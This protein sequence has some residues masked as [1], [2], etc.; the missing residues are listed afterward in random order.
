[1]IR[2]LSRR[3][4]VLGTVETAA[5]PALMAAVSTDAK[6]GVFYGP[7]WPGNVG[8]PPGEQKL[9]APLRSS[10]NAARMWKVSEELTG[11]TFS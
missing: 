11:V 4:L 1:M 10:E 3:G 2:W 5:L 8:G 6:D 7:Q 9:W